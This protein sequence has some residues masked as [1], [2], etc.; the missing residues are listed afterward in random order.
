MSYGPLI[1]LQVQLHIILSTLYCI[2][3]TLVQL[4]YTTK[5]GYA[6]EDTE[7]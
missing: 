2:W 5:P 6:S 4:L 3:K 1:T 7:K